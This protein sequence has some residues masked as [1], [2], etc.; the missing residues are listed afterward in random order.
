MN[1][2]DY[3]FDDLTGETRGKFPGEIKGQQFSIE[4]C[5]V[6]NVYPCLNR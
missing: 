1:P 2:A 4:N 3:C 5:K 6:C